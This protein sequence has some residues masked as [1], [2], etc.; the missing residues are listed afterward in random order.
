MHTVIANSFANS[1]CTIKVISLFQKISGYS[2]HGRF[3]FVWTPYLSENWGVASHIL[4]FANSCSSEPHYFGVVKDIFISSQCRCT[5][6]I[7][8]SKTIYFYCLFVY[9]TT[10]YKK[11]KLEH[12]NI[13]Y[14]ESGEE[15]SGETNKASSL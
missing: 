9:F 8:R 6:L 10:R 5:I 1:G 11:A 4:F 13:Y 3:I 15:A 2:P 14:R 7:Y 12:K